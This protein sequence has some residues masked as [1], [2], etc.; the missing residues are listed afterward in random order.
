MEQM[1]KRL[2]GGGEGASFPVPHPPT[3]VLR[4]TPPSSVLRTRLSGSEASAGFR[5]QGPGSGAPLKP[6]KISNVFFN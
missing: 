2:R 6:F 5:G 3:A 1:E 4:C